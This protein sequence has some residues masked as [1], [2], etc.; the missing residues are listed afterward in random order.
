MG[1]KKLEQLT[2]NELKSRRKVLFAIIIIFGVLIL[3]GGGIMF[4]RMFNGTW[5]ANNS[6]GALPFAGAAVIVSALTAIMSGITSELKK[7]GLH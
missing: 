6:F 1:S 5:P 7:R 4:Y 2:D 3:V